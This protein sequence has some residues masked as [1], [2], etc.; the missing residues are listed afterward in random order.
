MVMRMIWKV[1]KKKQNIAI[2]DFKKMVFTRMVHLG[3][4]NEELVK[5]SGVTNSK[6]YGLKYG[7]NKSIKLDEIVKIAKVLDIDL[8]KLKGE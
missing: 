3:M 4:S 2:E 5:L 7:N 1:S 6:V 8:N